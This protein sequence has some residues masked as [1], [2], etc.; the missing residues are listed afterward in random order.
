MGKKDVRIL[1]VAVF[2]YLSTVN[3]GINLQ[4]VYKH[5]EAS[6]TERLVTSTR[7]ADCT[8]VVTAQFCPHISK[9]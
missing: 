9:Y 6:E 8:V 2:R 1:C 7:V 3:L 4:M 5:W